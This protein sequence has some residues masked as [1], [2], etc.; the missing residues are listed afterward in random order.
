MDRAPHGG[1]GRRAQR[2]G[3]HDVPGPVE[4]HWQDGG[5][6]V[7]GELE[8]A[9]LEGEHLALEAARTFRRDPHEGALVEPPARLADGPER[10]PRVGAVD[11]DEARRA[12]GPAEDGYVEQ[13]ALGHHADIGAEDAKENRDVVE[14]LVVAH[15]DVALAGRAPLAPLELED[16][17]GLCHDGARPCV[18]ARVAPLLG[19]PAHG[20][21]SDALDHPTAPSCS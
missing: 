4:R 7:D 6:G 17:P 20:R 3:W 21:V 8:T 9:G 13:L 5:L 14:R 11:G 19:D 1:A 18:E 15:D 2:P 12:H 16:D 10:S